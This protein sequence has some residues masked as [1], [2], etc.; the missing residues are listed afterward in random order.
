MLVKVEKVRLRLRDPKRHFGGEVKRAY[1]FVSQKYA[2]TRLS[3][4]VGSFLGGFSSPDLL[5]LPRPQGRDLF[6]SF[7]N[8]AARAAHRLKSPTV[9]TPSLIARVNYRKLKQNVTALLIFLE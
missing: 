4:L 9:S 7:R 5:F 6:C 2:M 8:L 3:A 1:T